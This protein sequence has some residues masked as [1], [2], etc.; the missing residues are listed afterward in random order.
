MWDKKYSAKLDLEHY[1][2]KLKEQY[3]TSVAYYY[4]KAKLFAL[5]LKHISKLAKKYNL[6]VKQIH[7]FTLKARKALKQYQKFKGSVLK[8][9]LEEIAQ[10]LLEEGFPEEAIEELIEETTKEVYEEWQKLEKE[11]VK[12]ALTP[13]RMLANYEEYEISAAPSVYIEYLETVEA[14]PLKSLIEEA[15]VIVY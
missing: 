5:I 4:R 12:E 15:E 3:L 2:R 9:K 10:Q 14:K 13:F 7:I 1:R 6:D 8:K 11:Y